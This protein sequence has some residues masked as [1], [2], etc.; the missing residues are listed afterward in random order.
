MICLNYIQAG[1]FSR[2]HVHERNNETVSQQQVSFYDSFPLGDWR[3]GKAQVVDGDSIKLQGDSV[4]LEGIDA[5]ERDQNC[6]TKTGSEVRCGVIA[7]NALE[8]FIADSDVSCFITGTD[9]Y[10]RLL[11]TCFCRMKNINQWMVSSGNALAYREYSLLYIN[12]E[13]AAKINQQ[14]LWNYESFMNPW[15]WR[16]YKKTHKEE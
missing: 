11:G 14:G 9:K 10:H 16:H 3:K 5:L 2:V 13:E 12:E 6:R 4:R 8:G 7:T 15:D 1:G